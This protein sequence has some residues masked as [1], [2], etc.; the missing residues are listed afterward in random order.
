MKYLTLSTIIFSTF[1]TAPSTAI[2]ETFDIQGTA[3][4]KITATELA[5]FNSPWAMTVL[6]NDQMLVTT[7]PGKIWLVG[8]SGEKIELSGVP[9]AA[10]GGQGG[11]GD[12]VPHPDFGKNQTVYLSYVESNDNGATRGSV[13]VRATLD[14]TSEPKLTNIEK[15]W[16]QLPKT[17]GRGHFSHKIAFGPKGT[18][19][20]GKL[21]ITSGDRQQQT[22]A[23]DWDKALG[24]IIR[25]NE[26]GSVPSDNPYQNKG[27]LAKSFWTVG[28]RNLLGISFDTQ[29]KLW[30][31]EMGPKHGDE[32]NLIEAGKN[33][34]WP[35][36][37]NG[38][39][40]NGGIIPNHNTRPEFEA[41]KA[42]WVPSIAPSGLVIYS[43]KMFPKFNGNAFIGGLVSR[44]LIRVE[45]NGGTAKEAERFEWGKRIREVEQAPDGALYVLEDKEGGRLLR[46]AK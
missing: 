33:Y 46:L 31:H 42:Y 32:L 30:S 9:K 29:G 16:T 36:V 23:Q 14:T 35:V 17:S 44:A 37:S 45:I 2:A 4:S 3:G 6:T 25:L 38:N 27:D 18:K 15:V 28:H 8:T 21:F 41:P 39:N 5:V 1:A 20:D 12:I 40:Y 22:P 34:G 26:D 24:K 10:V 11:L 7:K 13:V 43:G 19:H